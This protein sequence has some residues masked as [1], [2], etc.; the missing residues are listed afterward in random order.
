WARE[1]DGEKYTTA[2]ARRVCPNP[3]CRKMLPEHDI[4]ETLNIAV[5]GDTFSGKT[6]YIAVLIDQL[7]RGLL[8]QGSSGSTRLVSLNPDTDR[9]YQDTYYIPILQQMEA[10]PLGTRPGRFDEQ[11]QPIKSDPLVY[12]L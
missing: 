12:Q 10:K 7:K 6:H 3:N 4:D 8:V 1:L 9:M 2:L 5:V 11:G